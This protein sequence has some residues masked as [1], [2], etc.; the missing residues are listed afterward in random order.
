MYL[1]L[2]WLATNYLPCW[3]APSFTYTTC[4][5][6]TLRF[7]VQEICVFVPRSC[8][9]NQEK[10]TH[11]KTPCMCCVSSLQ[12]WITFVH[13]QLLDSWHVKLVASSQHCLKMGI[14]L[15]DFLLEKSGEGHTYKSSLC[16]HSNVYSLVNIHCI[17]YLT[18]VDPFLSTSSVIPSLKR[19]SELATFLNLSPHARRAFYCQSYSHVSQ[20]TQCAC[21]YWKWHQLKL[22]SPNFIDS[23]WA[24]NKL[25]AVKRGGARNRALGLS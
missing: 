3:I 19:G 13:Y 5:I 2:R 4:I 21:G 7:Y 16:V 18:A 22:V 23:M 14:R 8:L 24:S 15:P 12:K 10:G 17:R 25:H 9:K 11:A 20:E 6:I 1:T